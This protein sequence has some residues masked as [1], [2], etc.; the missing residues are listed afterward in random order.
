VWCQE[1]GEDVG[2]VVVADGDSGGQ[3]WWLEM[4]RRVATLFSSKV[5]LEFLT[6]MFKKWILKLVFNRY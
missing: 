5:E 4:K 3:W 2:V 6:T 1:A